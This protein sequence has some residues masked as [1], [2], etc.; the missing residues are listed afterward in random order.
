MADPP[1]IPAPNYTQIPNVIFE[2]M[3]DKNAHLTEAELRVILAIARKTF[4]WHKKRDK[5]SLSQLE[6]LTAM[7]RTSVK[8]G[9][10]AAIERGL[11]RRTPDTNDKRGGFFYELVVEELNDSTG[12]K[13]VLVQNLDQSKINTRTS[14]NSVPE[15]VQNLYPQ[16]KDK[17]K[18]ERE[19]EGQS[20]SPARTPAVQAYFDTYPNQTLNTEQVA[21]INRTVTDI[22]RWREV[23]RYW[24]VNNHRA[25]SVDSMLD[26]YRSGRTVKDD[27]PGSNGRSPPEP[28]R[29][30]IP[31]VV[32][33]PDNRN[34]RE[35]T[36]RKLAAEAEK[37]RATSQ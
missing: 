33:A 9:L 35:E 30:I 11:V 29:P 20:E 10:D 7:T 34:S 28:N 17:E 14:T 15:L 31:D 18:K 5:I 23:L 2:L 13:S 36:A 8:S 6:A 22:K 4:G 26:R 21:A 3:A 24:K 32:P 1:S 12:T 37:R 25:Q 19:S 16:K 27:R